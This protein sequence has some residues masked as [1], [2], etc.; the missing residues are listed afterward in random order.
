MGTPADR[1]LLALRAPAE[2]AGRWDDVVELALS[3][4]VAPLL[5]ERLRAAGMRSRLPPALATALDRE[6][7]ATALAN[8]RKLGEFRRLAVDCARQRIPLIPLKGLHLAELV[9]PDP[10]LRPMADMDVLV[11]RDRV[12]DALRVLRAAGYGADIDADSVHALLPERCNV[13]VAHEA[14]GTSIELHWALDEKGGS[15]PGPLEEIWRDARPGRLGDAETLL[16]PPHLLLL[17][18][19]THL[20]YNHAFAF[21]LRAVCDI[22]AIVAR[23]PEL[24]WSAFQRVALAHRYRPGVRVCLD[25]AREDLG[26]RIPALPGPAAPPEVMRDARAQLAT[27]ADLPEGLAH[28]PYL[29]EAVAKGTLVARA[30]LVGSRIFLPREELAMRYGIASRSRWLGLWYVRRLVD[31][32]RRYAFPALVLGRDDAA[33]YVRL[34]EWLARA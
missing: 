12:A 6:R 15:G 13:G 3:H 21:S 31:L 32:V 34:R 1:L 7:E 33:R 14:H 28:A 5:Q 30:R 24:D 20:A 29:I 23:H 8:L 11:P 22:D 4:G 19:C 26:T 17:H 16:L 2:S 25:L 18:V 10:S 27:V 9:Y